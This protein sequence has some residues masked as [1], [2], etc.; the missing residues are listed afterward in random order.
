MRFLFCPLA[1]RGYV[2]PMVGIARELRER[3]H[4]VALL[5]GSP[6]D[7]LLLQHGFPPLKRGDE[8]GKGFAIETWAHPG[9][10]VSQIK[11]L[12]KTL[13]SFF[14]DILIAHQLTLGPLIVSELLHIPIAVLGFAVYL[15]PKNGPVDSSCEWL[16]PRIQWRRAEFCKYLNLARRQLRLPDIELD[17]VEDYLLGDLFLLQS[18]PELEGGIAQ[19]PAQVKLVGSCLWEPPEIDRELDCWLD[20]CAIS[21]EPLVYLN[22]GRLFDAP[23]SWPVLVEALGRLPVRVAASIARM[24]RPAGDCPANV[25]ARDHFPQGQVLP[26]ARAVVSTANT[27]V[28]LGAVT[29]GLPSVL[30]PSGGEQVDLAQRCEA[31]GVSISLHGVEVTQASVLAAIDEALYGHRLRDRATHLKERFCCAGGITCA[32]DSLESFGTTRRYN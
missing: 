17:S 15:L 3:G 28:V 11:Q 21:G 30:V 9:A 18:V 14:P 26:K 7:D 27:T 23:S 10:V 31:A 8:D 5:T 32:A 24:D 2:Y 19:L 25:L 12:T 1:S 29:H 22:H 6:F 20:D 16:T 13:P 4:S